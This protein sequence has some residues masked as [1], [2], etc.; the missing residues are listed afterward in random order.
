MALGVHGG[1][2]P[3]AP[4]NLLTVPFALVQYLDHTGCP[5]HG[6]FRVGSFTSKKIEAAPSVLRDH[7]GVVWEGNFSAA[8]ISVKNLVSSPGPFPPPSMKDNLAGY[9]FVCNEISEDEFASTWNN[10]GF[11]KKAP[12]FDSWVLLQGGVVETILY[13]EVAS[14]H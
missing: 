5:T 3:H 6:V 1:T 10:E 14:N 9:N 8:A 2:A 11:I 7:E 13:K 4:I 12:S